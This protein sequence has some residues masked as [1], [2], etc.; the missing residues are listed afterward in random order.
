[1][2]R[3]PVVCA[4]V[5]GYVCHVLNGGSCSCCAFL[6]SVFAHLAPICHKANYINSFFSLMLCHLGAANPGT[7]HPAPASQC[8]E[9]EGSARVCASPAHNPPHPKANAHAPSQRFPC[10]KPTCARCQAAR[11]YQYSPKPVARFRPAWPRL[12]CGSPSRGPP[13]TRFCVLSK[14]GAPCVACGVWRGLL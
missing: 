8:L 10:P 9:T 5:W 1:M 3:S 11:D 6:E 14:P 12:S 4:S 2:T 13:L 7:D